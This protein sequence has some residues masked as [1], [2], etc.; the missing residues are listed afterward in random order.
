[1][2]DFP[3]MSSLILLRIITKLGFCFQK[4]NKKTVL[5]ESVSVA[6]SRHS[7][8]R[9]IQELLS[10]GYRL[11]Y[12]DE[13]W[14]RQNHTLKYGWQRIGLK[15]PSGAG[16]D[17]IVVHILNE[18]GFLLGAEL[19]FVGKKGTGDY[20]NE[21]K[22][23]HYIEWFKNVLSLLPL[24]PSP[25]VIDETLYHTKVYPGTKNPNNSCLKKDIISWI[26]SW[27]INLLPGM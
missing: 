10:Q 21:M 2:S 27:S 23:I 25:I 5:M 1:M 6:A 17:I 26:Q 9:K 19:C 11:F 4:L 15:T 3:N 18:D 12:T 22:S 13:T 20:H 14:C 7:F 24:K 8:L 16:K